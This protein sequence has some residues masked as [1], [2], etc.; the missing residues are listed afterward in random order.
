MESRKFK[1]NPAWFPYG[2]IPIFWSLGFHHSP[3]LQATD[4]ED[5]K[6]CAMLYSPFT[7]AFQHSFILKPREATRQ[8]MY[9]RMCPSFLP[10]SLNVNCLFAPRVSDS[11]MFFSCGVTLK[12]S[13]CVK[14][15]GAPEVVTKRGVSHCPCLCFCTISILKIAFIAK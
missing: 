7:P 1:P 12:V 11:S 13:G 6:Y 10:V 15:R 2:G 14:L 3:A 5:E 9:S 8:C 4:R